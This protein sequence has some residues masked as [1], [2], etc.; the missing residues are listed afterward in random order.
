MS[1][2]CYPRRRQSVN[3]VRHPAP[4]PFGDVTGGARPQDRQKKP[5]PE[6]RAGRAVHE[7]SELDLLAQPSVRLPDV[8]E[9]ESN[10]QPVG[11]Q[12]KNDQLHEGSS[13]PRASAST[14]SHG[15]LQAISCSPIRRKGGEI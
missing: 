13:S 8:Q 1:D 4:P 12:K 2:P 9:R 15:F 3:D 6:R 11:C 10:R 7:H 5:D 14:T